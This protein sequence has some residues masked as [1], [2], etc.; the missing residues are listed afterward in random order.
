MLLLQP[1]SVTVPSAPG[2]PPSMRTGHILT[3]GN[4]KHG[5]TLWPRA[6]THTITITSDLDAE[7]TA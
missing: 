1:D 4:T 6:L 2:I 5:G 3:P 7:V